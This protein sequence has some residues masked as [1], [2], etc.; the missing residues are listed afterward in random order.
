M[1]SVADSMA[2]RRKSIAYDQALDLAERVYTGE[3]PDHVVTSA[4]YSELRTTYVN[5]VILLDD[6]YGW[7]KEAENGDPH[8]LVLILERDGLTRE[9]AIGGTGNMVQ[10]RLDRYAE[11]RDQ[12]LEPER[13]RLDLTG[14]Q[15]RTAARY[16]ETMNRVIQTTHRFMQELSRS[17]DKLPSAHPRYVDDL[18][19]AYRQKN[20]H[21][22]PTA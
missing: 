11:I 15:T 18:I 12:K 19:G 8:C 16:V 2:L 21:G 7:R 4:V 20:P 17:G 5:I 3:L 6:F 22:V 9:Q 1:L 10:T 14:E 13:A